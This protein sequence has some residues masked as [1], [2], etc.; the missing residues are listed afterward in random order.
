M[1]GSTKYIF[2]TGGVTSSLGKGII[3]ASLAKLLQARG[4][5]VTIQKLDPYINVDPGTLNPYEHGECF[6]TEDGAETDLDLGHYERFL[7]VPTSQ[8]NN[9]TTGR[10]YQNVINK[11]RRGEYLGKTVQVIPHITDEIKR[12]IQ[13]LGRKGIYDFV[14]TEVGGTV[15]DI[16][17]LPYVE[18]IRQLKWEKGKDCLTIH[19]TLLPF[20]QTSGELKTKP[21]QHSVKEMLSLGVQP[22]VLV[23]RTEHPMQK[24]MKEKIALFC[25]VDATAV[26]E[27]RDAQTIYDVPMMMQEEGLDR[28]VLQKL[29][30]TGY[31]EADLSAWTDFLHRY[32]EP[33]REVH[34]GLVGKYVEL[35]DA[36]KSIKEAL[37]H[38]GAENETKVH[39][40]WVH[41]EKL[42]AKNVGKHL[43]G[44]TGIVVAPGFGHRGIE[45]KIEAI[46]YAREQ[47]VPFLGICLGMQ[48]AVIEFGRNVLGLTDANS[49][50][51]NADTAHPVIAMM[52]EQKNVENKGG[53]MRL[54]AYPCK[55]TEGSTA[56]AVY[57]R[58]DI[59]ERH[60]HRYEFN[61]SYLEDYRKAGMEATGIN[62]KGKLVEIVEVKGHPWFVGVQFHPEYRSTV[63]KPH[64]LFVGF[65]QAAVKAA[66]PVG[67]KAEA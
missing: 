50:E 25:N 33:K 14:I 49:T 62:P 17:S 53:T 15:G 52:E 22:D 60:R 32:K 26:I 30:I 13:A 54:G 3:S 39:I 47:K 37:E 28:V 56:Y 4:F 18:S 63:M 48:C 58:K 34:I 16:E 36:Y 10:I 51:M 20:L 38:A 46:K 12:H 1:T 67:E 57:G 24:G 8:A 55:L 11:E 61:N 19:L 31:P 2:V 64:P 40:K 7:D 66:V 9:V 45:G 65:V 5:T 23:C 29:G 44:L 21:T 59:S 35:H 43:A 6:V 27:S 41:S 42:N